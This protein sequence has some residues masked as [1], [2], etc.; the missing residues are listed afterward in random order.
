MST[1]ANESTGRLTVPDGRYDEAFLER[2]KAEGASLN[3]AP[4]EHARGLR[5]TV[6]TARLNPSTGVPETCEAQGTY[7][8]A[9]ALDRVRS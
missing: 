1:D 9:E 2:V 8:R 3:M 6:V 5:G 7:V 4:P